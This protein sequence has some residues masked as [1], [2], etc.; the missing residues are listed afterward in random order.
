MHTLYGVKETQVPFKSYSSKAHRAGEEGPAPAPRGRNNDVAPV[1]IEIRPGGEEI[2]IPFAVGA[3]IQ[4]N[5]FGI[6]KYER[7]NKQLA[8]R[9]PKWVFCVEGFSNERD[10]A[11][12]YQ[13]LLTRVDKFQKKDEPLK[14]YWPSNYFMLV[15]KKKK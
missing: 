7:E 14:Q 5:S 13:V 11:G 15:I 6:N 4:F 8:A 10:E 1:Q 9:C 3:R 2:M 12:N